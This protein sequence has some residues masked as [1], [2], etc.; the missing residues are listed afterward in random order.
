MLYLPVYYG[1]FFGKFQSDVSPSY[2]TPP[3]YI[4]YTECQRRISRHFSGEEGYKNFNKHIQYTH[5][6]IL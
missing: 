2:C 4:D 5:V 6:F 3:A 1:F